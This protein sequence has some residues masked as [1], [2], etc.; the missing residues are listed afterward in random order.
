MEEMSSFSEIIKK[1]EENLEE[2]RRFGV[3]RIG[4]FGSYVRG[5][6]RKESDIDILVEFEEGKATLENFLDLKE[7][8][9]KLLGKKVDLLTR[10]GVN[11]IRIEY[12]RKEIEENVVY[13]SQ[14]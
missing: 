8:L 7:Y 14:R 12:I 6:Q 1:M 3:K 10:E 11:S 5:E 4:V 13:V 2:I 9:E